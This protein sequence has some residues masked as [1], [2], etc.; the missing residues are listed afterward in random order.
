MRRGRRTCD[1]PIPSPRAISCRL[2]ATPCAAHWVLS[3]SSSRSVWRRDNGGWEDSYVG[4]RSRLRWSRRPPRRRPYQPSALPPPP[5]AAGIHRFPPR[6]VP[7]PLPADCRPFPISESYPL[8]FT[9]AFV[10][11]FTAAAGS[12]AART[13]GTSAAVVR[14]D[15]G[16]TQLRVRDCHMRLS[17]VHLRMRGGHA[18]MRSNRARVRNDSLSATLS[19]AFPCCQAWAWTFGDACS[20]ELCSTSACSCIF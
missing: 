7:V 20:E 15:E 1:L 16:A 3:V 17:A 5:E 12:V 2:H 14:G 10:S 18:W 9:M 13:S 19:L 4:I 11:T 6:P 8:P